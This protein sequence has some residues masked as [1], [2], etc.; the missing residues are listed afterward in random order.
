MSA[1]YINFDR[2]QRFEVTISSDKR[3]PE[4]PVLNLKGFDSVS[5]TFT[6]EQF[7]QI[8]RAIDGANEHEPF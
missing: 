7:A 5:L 8:S 2:A 6:K 1:H 3:N 4:L